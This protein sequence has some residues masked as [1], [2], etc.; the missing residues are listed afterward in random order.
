MQSKVRRGESIS[1][2]EIIR[3]RRRNYQELLQQVKKLR[4]GEQENQDTQNE[5]DMS[6]YNEELLRLKKLN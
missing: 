3:K 6:N 2:E 5:V 4:E 1:L